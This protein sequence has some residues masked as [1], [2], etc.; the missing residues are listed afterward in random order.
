MIFF[1]QTI[2]LICTSFFGFPLGL[3]PE[4]DDFYWTENEIN[5]QLYKCQKICDL[6]V[7][8]KPSQAKPLD[9]TKGASIFSNHF[10]RPMCHYMA[11]PQ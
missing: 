2:I 10:H 5:K 8:N 11:S 1:A 3:L 9:K 7:C 4:A 6:V